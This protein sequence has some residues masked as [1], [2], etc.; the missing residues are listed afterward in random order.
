MA[1]LIRMIDEAP[2]GY[3]K[4]DGG[5]SVKKLI[6]GILTAGA[7]LTLGTTSA[8]AAG[9]H[10][11]TCGSGCYYVDADGDGICDNHHDNTCPKTGLGHGRGH[12]MGCGRGYGCAY[13]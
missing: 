5:I 13:R 2:K 11:G 12:G 1:G 3:L 9:H 6:A 10:G 8:F 4:M 7:L